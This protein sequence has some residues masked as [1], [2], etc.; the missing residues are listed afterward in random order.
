MNNRIDTEP[1]RAW[2]DGSG[3]PL[4]KSMLHQMERFWESQRKLL[5]EYESFSRAMLERRRSAADSTLDTLRKMGA[6]TDGADWAKCYSDWLAGSFARVA[7]DSRDVLQEGWKLFSEASQTM[8]AGMA[9]TAAASAESATAA[10]ETQQSVAR[11][12]SAQAAAAAEQGSSAFQDAARAAAA[13]T[14]QRPKRPE[15]GART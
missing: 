1:F 8:T 4:R 9:E 11:A 14:A 13:R 7:E 15:E 5:D 6:C 10:A 3:E 12:A 2:M